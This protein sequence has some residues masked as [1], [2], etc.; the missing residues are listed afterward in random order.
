[1]FRTGFRALFLLI[2]LPCLAA[3]G[4]PKGTPPGFS[5]D[6]PQTANA[7]GK[8][9]SDVGAIDI[10]NNLGKIEVQGTSLTAFTYVTVP[11]GEFNLTIHQGIAIDRTHWYVYFLYCKPDGSIDS[12]W[13]EGTNGPALSWEAA[14]GTCSNPAGSSAPPPA[15]SLPIVDVDSILPKT[16]DADILINGPRFNYNGKEHGSL[17]KSAASDQVPPEDLSI[18]PFGFV[19]CTK[20]CGSDA[21]YELHSIFVDAAKQ[22]ACFAIVYGSAGAA[23][24]IDYW[25]CLPD[26][27][28]DLQFTVGT[29]TWSKPGN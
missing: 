10:Q 17:V 5:T 11:W 4:G 9:T 19:D 21:W 12:I 7:S 8:G 2:A 28:S 18:Y 25:I 6:S 3:C 16:L 13:L 23:P 24:A 15:G 29:S 14:S 27:S 1:M 20:N 26:L 22:R